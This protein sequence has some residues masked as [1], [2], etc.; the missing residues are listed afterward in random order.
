[1]ED[2]LNKDLTELYAN[3]VDIRRRLEAWNATTSRSRNLSLAIT[4]LEDVEDKLERHL[5]QRA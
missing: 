5:T 3:L 2:L 4:R 1:M